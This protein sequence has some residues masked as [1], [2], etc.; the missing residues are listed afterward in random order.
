MTDLPALSLRQ[1][2]AQKLMLDIRF[3][4]EGEGR[5][6]VTRLTPGLAE[7]LAELGPCGVILFAENLD[8]I[9]QSIDLCEDIQQAL[10]LD[11][12]GALVGIDQE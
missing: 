10:A 3:F 2:I 12:R 11:G 8:S 4:D 1:C 7:G 9:E 5:A 6:A